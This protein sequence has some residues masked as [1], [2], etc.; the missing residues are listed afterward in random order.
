VWDLGRP[1]V[2]VI[3]PM[4]NAPRLRI[5]EGPQ[6]EN[7]SPSGHRDAG[8]PE[9][10]ARF[11][12]EKGARWKFRHLRVTATLEAQKRLRDSNPR[13]ARGGNFVTSGSPRC[14]TPRK[15]CE[16]RIRE[17]REVENSSPSGHRDAPSA[18]RAARAECE[19]GPARRRRRP[20]S[21]TRAGRAR[22]HPRRGAGRDGRET[23]ARRAS[24]QALRALRTWLPVAGRPKAWWPAPPARK[25]GEA[26]RTAGTANPGAHGDR[27]DPSDPSAW[28]YVS[29][30]GA[31]FVAVIAARAC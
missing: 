19:H 13:R 26:R 4:Q 14:W 24:A 22:P 23:A 10:S 2:T 29:S 31:T 7:S 5:P 30:C 6:Q 8:S 11:E 9:K 28:T 12:S 16:T 1:R 21:S 27:A 18:E 15:D 25:N 17:G 20:R 3:A